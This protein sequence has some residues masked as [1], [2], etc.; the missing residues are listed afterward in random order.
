MCHLQ[1]LSVNIYGLDY[2]ENLFQMKLYHLACGSI[3]K[4]Q[5]IMLVKKKN[6]F[7]DLSI[8]LFCT[9]G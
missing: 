9:A 4:I 1:L 2:W 5:D 3:C 7:V 6:I 8:S